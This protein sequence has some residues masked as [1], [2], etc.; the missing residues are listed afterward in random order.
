MTQ[1]VYGGSPTASI[2]NCPIADIPTLEAGLSWHA[3][4]FVDAFNQ[5]TRN[6]VSGQP[7]SF[8]ATKQTF[9]GADG[10]WYQSF[11]LALPIAPDW[12]ING[13]KI[14]RNVYPIGTTL[15]NTLFNTASA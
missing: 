15:P 13:K 6:I 3:N 10:I 2:I 5:E 12:E 11:Q 7:K 9:Q 14:W 1:I 8:L 4:A